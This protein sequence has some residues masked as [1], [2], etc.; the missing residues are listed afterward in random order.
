MKAVPLNAFHLI[1]P[2]NRQ[3]RG[4]A[5]HRGVKRGVKAG[6]LRQLWMTHEMPRST[7]FRVAGD[8][9]RRL[10]RD[11]VGRARQA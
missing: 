3:Q 10:L 5:R 11:A 7:R 8:Q 4:D 9:V 6:H 2:R 1:A